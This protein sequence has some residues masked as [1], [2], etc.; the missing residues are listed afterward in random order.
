[1]NVAPGDDLGAD[2]VVAVVEVMKM[3]YEVTSGV[4]GTVES[5]EVEAGAMVN[6]GDTLA[7]VRESGGA[8]M[9]PSQNRLESAIDRL[10][11][12]S[13]YRFEISSLYDYYYHDGEPG[14]WQLWGKGAYVAPNSHWWWLEAQGG[15]IAE[16]VSVDGRTYCTHTGFRPENEECSLAWGAPGIGSSPYTVIAY[17]LC[18]EEARHEGVTEFEGEE[19]DRF[20]FSPS[21]KRISAIDDHHAEAAAAITKVSGEVLIRTRDQLP[22][23]ETVVV[24]FPSEHEGA[25]SRVETTLVFS[26]FNESVEIKEPTDLEPM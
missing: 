8:D 14:R 26:G 16:L 20:G 24:L 25:E 18:F 6:P 22:R 19:C 7:R 23:R 13:S 2:S 11:E 10:A 4:A 12:L 21:L 5:V 3:M 17:L 9:V 15:A 1:V